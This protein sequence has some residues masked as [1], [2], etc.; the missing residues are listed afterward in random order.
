M[1]NMARQ[2][3]ITKHNTR[4]QNIIHTNVNNS[5]WNTWYVWYV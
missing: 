1:A 3:Y 4:K 5:Q 2:V